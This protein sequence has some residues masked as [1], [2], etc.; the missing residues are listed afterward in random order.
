MR[1]NCEKKHLHVRHYEEGTIYRAPTKTEPAALDSGM[2]PLLLLV[3][4]GE[5]SIEEEGS[6]GGVAGIVGGEEEGHVGDVVGSAEALQRNIFEQRIELGGIVKKIFVDRSFDGAGSDG[7]D[8]DAE[9][10]EF[11]GEVASQHFDAT[12]AGAVGSEVR[13]GQFFVH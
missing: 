10:R 13:E 8:G 6:T 3:V 12:L 2:T 1:K 11:D 9:G 7:I 4:P 5:A